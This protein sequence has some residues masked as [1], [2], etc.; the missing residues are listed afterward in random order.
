MCHS[1]MAESC[2]GGQD[3]GTQAVTEHI[4]VK[5]SEGKTRAALANCYV[6]RWIAEKGV[7]V[8]AGRQLET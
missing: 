2:D 7:R 5:A 4:G 3:D 6:T 1:P 8:K